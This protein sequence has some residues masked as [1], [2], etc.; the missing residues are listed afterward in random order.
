MN[1]RPS[2]LF[3]LRE[4]LR[5]AAAFFVIYLLAI[6]GIFVISLSVV[7][8]GTAVSGYEVSACITVFVFGIVTIRE[9]LRLGLQNGVSRRTVYRAALLSTLIVTLLLAAAG[10]LLAIAGQALIVNIGEIEMYSIYQ[11][12]FANTVSWLSAPLSLHLGSI[13]FTFVLLNC[14]N[15]AGSFISLVFY[16]LNKLWTIVVAVGT[17]IFLGFVLPLAL[18]RAEIDLVSPFMKLTASPLTFTAFFAAIAV[19]VAVLNRLLLLRAPI[20]AAK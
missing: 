4:S 19:I 17:P 9:D 3:R 6:T 14:A 16:R 8:R 5:S 1:I 10:E 13:L 2:F 11:L 18:D 12:L 20:K 7:D 15:F